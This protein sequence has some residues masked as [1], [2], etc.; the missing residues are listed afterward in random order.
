[1]SAGGVNRLRACLVVFTLALM[2]AGAAYAGTFT[3]SPGATQVLCDGTNR[4]YVPNLVTAP[5]GGTVEWSGCDFSLHPLVSDDG[6]WPDYTGSA[7][8]GNV[9]PSDGTFKFHCA[10]HGV[11][12]G[13][14]KGTVVVGS[15]TPII[16][17]RSVRT[18]TLK[19]LRKNKAFRI[20]FD[21]NEP[22]KRSVDVK[23]IGKGGKRL[24]SIK[25]RDKQL[26]DTSDGCI[27]RKNLSSR[28]LRRLRRFDGKRVVFQMTLSATDADG[29]TASVE[30][31]PAT[32]T[33]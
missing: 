16:E 18:K 23:A 9:Y 31:D 30:T 28:V 10:L 4:V 27:M 25:L 6:L 14:M 19:S 12:G 7:L 20:C 5:V 26:V 1:M 13:L 8:F 32:P 22:V 17:K 24:F 15:G 21:A 33:K 2:S 3:P 29:K 11:N